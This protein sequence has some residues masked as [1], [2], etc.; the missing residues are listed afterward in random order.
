[1]PVL[2]MVMSFRA[3]R[4]HAP[5]T[6]AFVEAMAGMMFFTTPWVSW[7]VTPYTSQQFPQVILRSTP[8]GLRS[9]LS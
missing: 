8:L 5:A 1:M 6:M 3:S 9:T 4:V 2:H 7:Y